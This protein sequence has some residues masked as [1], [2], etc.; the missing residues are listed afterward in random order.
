MQLSTLS[1]FITSPLIN[2]VNN[3]CPV[4]LRDDNELNNVIEALLEKGYKIGELTHTDPVEQ[5]TQD[6]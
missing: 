4:L 3:A 6:L 2:K 1:S 5:S